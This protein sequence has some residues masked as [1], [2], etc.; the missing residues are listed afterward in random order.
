MSN[1]EKPKVGFVTRALQALAVFF[2]MVAVY[3]FGKAYFS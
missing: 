2:L 1:Q 3:Y